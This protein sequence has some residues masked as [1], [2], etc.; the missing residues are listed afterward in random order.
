MMTMIMMMMLLVV[1]HDNGHDNY[2]AVAHDI[3]VLDHIRWSRHRRM[4]STLSLNHSRTFLLSPYSR[5][6]LQVF[7]LRYVHI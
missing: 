6:W 2:G 5:G 4:G 3:I 1:M 7:I